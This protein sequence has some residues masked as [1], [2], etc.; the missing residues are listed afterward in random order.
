MTKLLN[1]PGLSVAA[2]KLLRNTEHTS[3][4]LAV[5]QETRRLM[6]FDTHAMRIRY[7]VPIFVT[8]PP[9]EAHSV[10]MVRLSRT[11]RRDP[12]FADGADPVGE[13]FCG[14]RQPRIAA[15]SDDV[16]LRIPV[17]AVID[18]LPT[19]DER[20]KLLARDSLGSM[21]GS[22]VLVLATYEYLFG[23]RVCPYGPDCNCSQIMD[24]CQDHF[25]SN[26]FTMYSY[27]N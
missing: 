20:R 1:V 26:A 9:H 12:V 24:P 22:R 14:R 15:S 8:L 21:D 19:Y 27:A 3:R 17:S 25:G 5:A 23:M 10:L 6:R 16:E 4:R 18:A 7:G 2:R 11:R 13:R